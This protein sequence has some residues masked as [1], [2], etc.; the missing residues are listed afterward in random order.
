MINVAKD[1]RLTDELERQLMMQAIED[2]Y[3][4]KPVEAIKK[5]FAKL[6]AAADRAQAPAGKMVESTN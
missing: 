3:R 6:F 1:V 5:L 2:Q 4:F